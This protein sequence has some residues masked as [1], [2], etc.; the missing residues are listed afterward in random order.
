MERKVTEKREQAK[1]LRRTAEQSRLAHDR[2]FFR[3]QAQRLDHQ[4]EEL[5]RQRGRPQRR[6]LDRG[7][8]KVA[9]RKA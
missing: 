1:R 2:A 5:E 6:A 4:A 9:R 3:R 7:Q 8:V